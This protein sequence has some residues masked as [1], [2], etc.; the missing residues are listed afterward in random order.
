M[1]ESPAKGLAL[2]DALLAEGVLRSYHYAPSV[3]GDLLEKFGRYAEARTEFER[4][5]VL[6]TNAREQELLKARA[7]ACAER[8]A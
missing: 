7:W 4:A 2:V 8:R 3:R 5:A 6:A 1:A